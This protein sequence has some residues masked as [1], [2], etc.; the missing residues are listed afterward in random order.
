MSETYVVDTLVR[1]RCFVDAK[2]KRAADALARS[3]VEGA[4]K[5]VEPPYDVKGSEV[6]AG[7]YH[8][9]HLREREVS[10]DE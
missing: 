7:V 4:I 2:N 3:I 5:P 1:R 9:D 8:I 10:V 6:V